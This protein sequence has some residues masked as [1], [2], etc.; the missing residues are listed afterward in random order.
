MKVALP[1][2][3]DPPTPTEGTDADLEDEEDT[4]EDEFL[5]EGRLGDIENFLD[6]ISGSLEVVLPLPTNFFGDSNKESIISSTELII[7]S[8]VVQSKLRAKKQ[9]LSPLS[10]GAGSPSLHL[11][12]SLHS[13]NSGLSDAVFPHADSAAPKVSF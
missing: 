10:V 8:L 6:S 5:E 9:M 11:W 1:L 12:P 3:S 2:F 13:E 4:E 7:F